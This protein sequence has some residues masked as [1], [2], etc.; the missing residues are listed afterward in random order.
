MATHRRRNKSCIHAA[1]TTSSFRLITNDPGAGSG[2]LRANSGGDV[3]VRV[4]HARDTE[5]HDHVEC[6][7][8]DV[9]H[10]GDGDVI[11]D[12]NGDEDYTNDDQKEFFDPDPLPVLPVLDMQVGTKERA[13]ARFKIVAELSRAENFAR[14]ISQDGRVIGDSDTSPDNDAAADETD[15]VAVIPCRGANS[16]HAGSSTNEAGVP[17]RPSDTGAEQT[18]LDRQRGEQNDLYL[19]NLS[20]LR[21]SMVSLFC[22]EDGSAGL[23]HAQRKKTIELVERSLRAGGDACSIYDV[24]QTTSS[25]SKNLEVLF[26]DHITSLTNNDGWVSRTF[27]VV[28]GKAVAHWNAK[29]LQVVSETVAMLYKDLFRHPMWNGKEYHHPCSGRYMRDFYNLIKSQRQFVGDWSSDDDFPLLLT[30]FS[31]ATLLANRGTLTAHPVVIGIGNLP[32]GLYASNLVTVGYLDTSIEYDTGLRPESKRLVKRSLVGMQVAAMMDQFVAASYE[33]CVV[34]LPVSDQHTEP[35][36]RVRFFPGLFDAALDYPEVVSLIGIKSGCCGMCYWKTEIGGLDHKGGDFRHGVGVRRT[37]KRSRYA[38]DA[39]RA[40][41]NKKQ[42]KQMVDKYGMHPQ[43]P[44]GL[45]G[46]N[47]SCPVECI[48]H[49]VPDRLR[50]TL[51]HWAILDRATDPFADRRSLDLHL[52]VS[53]E[54]MHEID[55]GLTCYLRSAIFKLLRADGMTLDTIEL[56]VNQPLLKAMTVESRW[57]GLF[58]PPLTREMASLTGYFGGCAKVQASEHRSVLQVLVP[59]LC[60]TLGFD[61]TV[62]RLAALYLKYYTTRECR[63]EPTKHHTEESLAETERLFNKF[64]QRLLELQ[65]G[66]RTSYNQPKIHSQ[67]HFSDRVRRAGLSFITTGEAGESQNAKVKA[68]Y[69]GG[70][71]NRQ[72]RH[73]APQ[74]VRQRRQAE[75]AGKLKRSTLKTVVLPSGPTK[76]HKYETSFVIAARTDSVA[77]TKHSNVRGRD[78]FDTDQ[79][80]NF[81]DTIGSRSRKNA[82]KATGVMAT[83]QVKS[84]GELQDQTKLCSDKLQSEMNGQHRYFLSL[85]G[86][87]VIVERFLSEIAWWATK[88][89]DYRT[90][91]D[92]ETMVLRIKVVRNAVSA[93]VWRGSDRR[94]SEHRILQ[95]LRCNPAFRTRDA[96]EKK[97][98]WNDFVA[99]RGQYEHLGETTWYARLILMFHLQCPS[100]GK[101]LQYAFVRYMTR[102]EHKDKETRRLARSDDEPQVTHL[103]YA[104]RR[105]KSKEVW[106]YGLILVECIDRKIQVIAGN[107]QAAVSLRNSRGEAQYWIQD[108]AAKFLV[109]NYVWQSQTEHEYSLDVGAPS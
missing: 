44:G 38:F 87:P 86:D 17:T 31:D 1:T 90:I 29:A 72:T 66:G 53:Q 4:A 34:Q 39:I 14:V 2:G 40:A 51:Q 6:G 82:Q 80:Q 68:P 61:H 99:I 23:T 43:R 74:L 7:N 10:A 16:R 105:V 67:L 12:A 92:R 36:R 89:R 102:V 84:F 54:T 79:L 96:D 11:D 76:D 5:A 48:P 88:E 83:P 70:L 26:M 18:D 24:V 9:P 41:P 56:T 94:E 103:K 52:V 71:T 77:F 28:G 107:D 37:E 100:S 104:T 63:L 81:V 21:S 64:H 60:R 62:T 46:F 13:Y 3:P 25:R 35:A 57:Q 30:Y 108:K 33:G 22:P 75:A 95:R 32:A 101:W 91:F 8:Y 98:I 19:A 45:W 47:G 69:K 55:L 15:G 73:V 109:N 78:I 85:F 93:S 27:E 59:V 106:Y 50:M 42:K 97:I 65:P 20:S 58:H 49:S